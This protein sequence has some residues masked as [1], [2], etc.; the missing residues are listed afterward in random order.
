MSEDKSL[1]QRAMAAFKKR[2]TRQAVAS[3]QVCVHCG[4]CSETCHYF[5]STDDPTMTPVYKMDKVRKVYKRTVDWLGR[6]APGWVGAKDLDEELLVEWVDVA[7]GSCTLCRR[8]MINCPM[9]VDPVQVL[10]LARGVLTE[11]EMTPEGLAATVNVHLESGNNM[12]ISEEDIRDTF[13]WMEE[14]LQDEVGDTKARIPLNKKGAHMMYT[15]NPREG[16]YF[17][18]TI[19]AAA[20]VFWAAGEDWTISTDI[21]D[22]TNYALF[23][24]DAESARTISKRIVETVEQ[25]EVDSLVMGECGHGYRAM[26][27]E[28]PN[29]LGYQPSFQVRSFIEVMADYI[30]QG[31][32]KVDPSANKERITY[33]DSCNV[34]R[35]AGIVDEPRYILRSCVEDF[36]DMEPQGVDNYCC[37]GGGGMMAMTEYTQQRLDVGKTKAEQI[38]ATGAKVVVTACHNCIDQLKDLSRRYKLDVE[39]KNV[40]EIV[41]DAIIPPEHAD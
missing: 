32:I 21:W 20:K 5:L 2:L 41:A 8:C 6:I 40:C 34:A 22:V 38:K 25:L 37:G 15:I 23:T 26:R 3:L 35:V 14:E 4:Q 30:K 1:E 36:V 27:W 16:K 28:A 29:W 18:L 19:Q 12:G 9:G 24:G 10:G 13:E 39:V 11:L 33:H 17:P 31:R 7:Y